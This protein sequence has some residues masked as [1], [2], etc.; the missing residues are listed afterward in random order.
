MLQALVTCGHGKTPEKNKNWR[1]TCSRGINTVS[2][3]GL[4]GKTLRGGTHA[5]RKRPS[6]QVEIHAL[7]EEQTCECVKTKYWS[8]LETKKRN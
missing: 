1:Q 5:F 6:N 7:K 2:T 4:K 3:V 8:A